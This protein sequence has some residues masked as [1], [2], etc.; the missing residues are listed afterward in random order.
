[1]K[2]ICIEQNGVVEQDRDVKYSL[3]W[4]A[5]WIVSL[6]ALLVLPAIGR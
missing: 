1:M 5:L 6:V 2:D 3:I 4:A